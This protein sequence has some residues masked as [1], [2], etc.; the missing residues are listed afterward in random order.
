L[1]IIPVQTITDCDIILPVFNSLSHVREA[2]TS[3]LECTAGVV[4]QLLLV[5]D[6]SDRRTAACLETIAANCPQATLLQQPENRG[7]VQSCLLGYSA[8][9]APFI[10]LLNS[11]VVVTPG[12]LE[13]LLAC[14]HSDPR[15]AAVNPLTNHAANLAVPMAPGAN[16]RGMDALLRARPPR[17]PDVVTCV[18]FCLLLRR[19]ALDQVG[20]FDPIFGHG[21]CE[22][23]DLCMRLTTQGFRTVIADDVY[24]Y[25][26][27]R[28]SFGAT[29]GERYLANRRIFDQ[30]WSRAYRRQ[31]AAFRD[32]NPLGEVRDLFALPTRFDPKPLI[33]QTGRAVL[34]AI[35][36]HQPVA[37]ARAAAQGLISLPSARSPVPDPHHLAAVTRPGRLRVTYIL[38]RLV[39][40]GGVLSVI[41][42][43]NALTRLDI[44]ARI[45]TLFEDPL[46]RDWTRLYTQPI[47]FR[48]AKELIARCP[49]SDVVIATH[50][51]TTA[52]ARA[53]L[54]TARARIGIAFLQDYEPWFF[55]ADDEAAR[56]KVRATF[57]LLDHRIVKSDW[58]AG[59]LARDGYSSHKIRLGMDLDIFYPRDVA[60][61]P[62]TLLAMARPGTPYRG[63]NNLI[64]AFALVKAAR[65][66]VGI[67]LF[68]DRDLKKQTLPFEFH[69]EGL[70]FDQDQLARIYSAADIFIDGS[71]FQ[72]FGRCGLEAM[73]CGTPCVLTSAGGVSEYAMDGENALLVPPQEPS[74]LALKVLA[75]L[76]NGGLRKRFSLAGTETARA[77]CYRREAHET[78]NFLTRIIETSVEI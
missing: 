30:R 23:S 26:R 45:L 15:I 71:D 6:A 51:T 8:S 5:D 14:A 24:L 48:N 52:W 3:V 70:V 61:H 43:V 63:F 46:V 58:L 67:R 20:F 38:P 11:D 37:A 2:V 21:Y 69:D 28:A 66:E 12:W 39:V 7:F 73:A 42:L 36:Q 53:I 60:P 59:M 50:W 54:D 31:F 74:K 44:E 29:R 68:G 13:R 40:A 27:G 10:C 77:Y 49:P 65:P 64:E 18:G 57:G 76:E 75:L 78:L 17:Y 56:T 19:A 22:E 35:R 4:Y 34:G 32:A 9:K 33:W 62:P 1:K 47:V 55:A 72:G 41:Q 25:H 16:Y